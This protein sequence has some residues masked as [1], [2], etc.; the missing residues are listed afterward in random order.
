[1][2]LTSSNIARQ[3]SLFAIL[4]MAMLFTPQVMAET[5]VSAEGEAVVEKRFDKEFRL[6]GEQKVKLSVAFEEYNNGH[7]R[8][9]IY[10]RSK[11]GGW[12]EL[13]D[14]RVIIKETTEL[15]SG[16]FT[17]PKGSYKVVVSSRR[18]YYTVKLEDS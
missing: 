11:Q 1:M 18:G 16:E 13:D 6:A 2:Q 14:Y 10:K 17:L 12:S 7:L 5:H 9:Y 3:F 8:V 4:C 15:K